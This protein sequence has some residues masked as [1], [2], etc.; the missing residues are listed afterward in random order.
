MQEDWLSPA[1]KLFGER[2]TIQKAVRAEPAMSYA[3]TAKMPFVDERWASLRMPVARAQL[4]AGANGRF[5]ATAGCTGGHAW[6]GAKEADGEQK[7]LRLEREY[8]A[9][10]LKI[11]AERLASVQLRDGSLYSNLRTLVP[12]V[13]L[14]TVWTGVNRGELEDMHRF[15]NRSV[16]IRHLLLAV[17]I[18]TLWNVWLVLS[19]FAGETVR[20]RFRAEVW[21]LAAASFVCGLLPLLENLARGLYGQGLLLA[22]LTAA[23]LLSTS[24]LLLSGFLAGALLWPKLLRPRVA[25]I[26]GSGQRAEMIK[27][28]LLRQYSRLEIFG[29]VDDEYFGSD[30]ETDNFLGPLSALPELLRTHPIEI[31]LI[32]LPIKSKYDEIQ[33]VIDVCEATG[34]ESHYMQDVF[35]TSRA[36]VENEPQGSRHFTVLRVQ[37]NDPKQ[38]VKRGFDL[39]VGSM[40]VVATAPVMMLAAL[41]VR[42]TSAGPVLF[43]QQRYGCNRK[44]FPMFKFRSMVEDAEARQASL[45]EANEATGPVFKLKRDPRV[46]RVGAFLRKT[47]IDELPQLFNVLR[48]EMSLVGPRPLPLRDVSRFEE[49]WLLRRFSVRPGLTCLWQIRGRSNTSFDNWMKLDLDYIDHW[50]LGLDLKILILTI[51]AVLRGS[52]AV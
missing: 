19:Q 45:E 36:R 9:R 51:P 1:P 16:G 12:V 3:P 42:V 7:R 13:V 49:A 10:Q 31:V 50:S 26:V 41:A 20:R 37:G 24:L 33:K 23:G 18:V 39:L 43:V 34:V 35:A 27:A 40:L 4:A 52:G 32:G 29:C 11:A 44:R 28:R 47:S 38:Y 48:G 46:T 30:A 5:G 14:A 15:L 8:G 22:S 6:S 2:K 25:L 17:L 21:S